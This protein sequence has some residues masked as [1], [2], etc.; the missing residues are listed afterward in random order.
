MIL[1]VNFVIHRDNLKPHPKKKKLPDARAM[2]R[3]HNDGTHTNKWNVVQQYNGMEIFGKRR[4]Q[5]A[6]ID[7][8]RH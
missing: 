6:D 3:L 2:L 4:A 7:V 5:E 8:T 1:V